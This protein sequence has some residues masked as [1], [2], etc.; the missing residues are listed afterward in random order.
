MSGHR[1]DA[2]GWDDD[3][4]ASDV[5]PDLWHDRLGQ[6]RLAEDEALAAA[7]RLVGFMRSAFDDALVVGWEPL[8]ETFGLPDIDDEHVVAAAVVGGAGAI[9]TDNLKHFPAENVLNDIQVL[10]A[11]VFTSNTADVNLGHAA[12]VI[13][14]ISRRHRNP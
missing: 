3:F 12:S 7:E 10:S 6:M 9:V 8:E 2:T 1:R 13:S 14:E 5:H 4:A 11:V